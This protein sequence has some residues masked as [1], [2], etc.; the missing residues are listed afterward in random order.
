ML[1]GLS[2]HLLDNHSVKI[3][4]VRLNKGGT[5]G[6][7][8]LPLLRNSNHLLLRLSYRQMD[9]NLD[10]GMRMDVWENKI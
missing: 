7:E 5:Q 6:L 2:F 10:E 3:Y 4:S 8:L 1:A 9:E